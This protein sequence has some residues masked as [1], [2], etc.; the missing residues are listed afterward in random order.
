MRVSESPNVS[1]NAIA[2]VNFIPIVIPIVFEKSATGISSDDAII[3]QSESGTCPLTL[4]SRIQK[5]H[6]GYIL[7]DTC[8]QYCIFGYILFR[9]NDVNILCIHRLRVVQEQFKQTLV[10]VVVFPAN[11]DFVEQTSTY[12]HI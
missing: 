12:N 6:F 10:D 3:R 8:T 5:H 7:A 1:D 2:I 11:L 4:W 9:T